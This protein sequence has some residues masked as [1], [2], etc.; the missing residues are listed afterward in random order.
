MTDPTPPAANYRAPEYASA[1]YT[2]GAVPRTNTLAIIALLLAITVPVAGIV[3][4]HL[5]LRQIKRSGESGHALALAA[6]ILGY[7]ATLFWLVM[8]VIIVG[9][10][11]LGLAAGF[12]AVA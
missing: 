7:V 8:I 6:T 2:P 4:G 10:T 9:A 11:V 5:A 3:C 12:W 1:P